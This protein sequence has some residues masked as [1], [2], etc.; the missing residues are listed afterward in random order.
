MAVLGVITT[1]IIRLSWSAA[2]VYVP[3]FPV[4]EHR[5]HAQIKF[6]RQLSLLAKRCHSAT[7]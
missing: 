1:E 3:L 5:T 4:L 7:I 2:T 6:S